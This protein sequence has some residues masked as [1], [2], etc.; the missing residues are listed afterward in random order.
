MSRGPRQK[1]KKPTLQQVFFI[2]GFILI[3]IGQFLLMNKPINFDR[4]PPPT[5]IFNLAGVLLVLIGFVIQSKK[6]STKDK[7][8]QTGHYPVVWICVAVILSGL[9][10]FSTIL[11][12]I[13]DFHN[14]DFVLITWLGT[15][16]FYLYAFKNSLPTIP[17]FKVW[18]KNHRIELLIVGGITLMALV[19][20]FVK[21]GVY[22]RVI[23]GDEGLIGLFAQSSSSGM[24][25]N[26]FAL[27]EN[28]GRDLPAIC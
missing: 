7:A 3:I 13:K 12:V 15:A 20:R 25:A 6:S 14:Y 16:V 8:Q 24:Y 5:F 9:T 2:L 27:W 4:L 23:D 11:F 18:I 17:Q 26:P 19:L 10:V 28:F 1:L 22:P 21:L